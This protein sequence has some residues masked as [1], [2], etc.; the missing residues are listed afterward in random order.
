M[1]SAILGHRLL[2]AGRPAAVRPRGRPHRLHVPEAERL[3]RATLVFGAASTGATAEAFAG[4]LPFL[5]FAAVFT[6]MR[7]LT[8]GRAFAIAAFSGAFIGA[9]PRARLLDLPTVAFAFF[10]AASILAFSASSR[11]ARA[12]LRVTR[13]SPFMSLLMS[14]ILLFEIPVRTLNFLSLA[15]LAFLTSDRRTRPSPLRSYL[16]L[17]SFPATKLGRGADRPDT[18]GRASDSGHSATL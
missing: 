4:G 10:F 8:T 9:A 12:S 6:V 1:R 2:A 7:F 14:M 13:P 16:L 17:I 15:S 5:L 11:A 3:R 18:M